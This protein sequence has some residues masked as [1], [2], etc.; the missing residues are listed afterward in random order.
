MSG[1]T[2]NVS[3]RHAERLK[4]HLMHLLRSVGAG[5]SLDYFTE[6][7]EAF[8]RVNPSLPRSSGGATPLEQQVQGVSQQVP[9][10]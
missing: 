7:V 1:A 6:D 2:G 3:H 5:R 9:D 10:C 8:V 4:D